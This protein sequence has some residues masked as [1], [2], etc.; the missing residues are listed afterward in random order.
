[1]KIIRKGQQF[2]D[3]GNKEGIVQFFCSKCGCIWQ[4]NNSEYDTIVRSFGERYARQKCPNCNHE[5]YEKIWSD[6]L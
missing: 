1:M 4:S 5:E 3:G 6:T 2:Y